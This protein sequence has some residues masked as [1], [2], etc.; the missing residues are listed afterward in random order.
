MGDGYYGL[1]DGIHTV[2]YDYT[3][4]TGTIT[5]PSSCTTPQ[6]VIG[7]MLILLQNQSQTE[8]KFANFTGNYVHSRA[9]VVY[10][11]GTVNS[12]PMNH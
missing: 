2:Q 7:L 4:F 8:V 1:A 6:T 3:G 9:K 10:T 12:I 11:D 5:I